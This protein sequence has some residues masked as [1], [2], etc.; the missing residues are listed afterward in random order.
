MERSSLLALLSAMVLAGL[1]GCTGADAPFGQPEK[2]VIPEASQPVFALLYV[3]DAKGFFKEAGREV[4]F[5]SFPLGR[6]ALGSV[7]EGATL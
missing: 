1:T 5:K 7:I 6:D 4:T 3:A 2:L